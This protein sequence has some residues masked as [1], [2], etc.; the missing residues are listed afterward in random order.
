MTRGRRATG[1]SGGARPVF[2]DVDGEAQRALI[3]SEHKYRDL[4]EH[5]PD[6]YLTAD[7]ATERIID[8]NQTLCDRLGYTKAELVGQLSTIVYPAPPSPNEAAAIR[9]RF[10]DTGAL[11]N[12]ERMLRCKDGSTIPVS[13][14]VR[15]IRDAANRI[16]AIRAVWRDI[17][18]QKQAERDLR[19]M[20]RLGEILRSS[21]DEADVLYAVCGEVARHL[22]VPRCSFAE[23]DEPAGR[24]VI[25]R[26]VH[27]DYPSVAG[28]VSLAAFAAPQADEARG[29]ATAVVN[30]TRTDPRTA[31]RYAAAYDPISIRSWMATPLRRDGA[32]VASLVVADAVPRRWEDREIHLLG[33]IAERVWV[34]VEHMRMLAEHR[35]RSIREAVERSEAR[36]RQLVEA[37]HDYAVFMLDADGVITSWNAGAQRIKG[38]T[39]EEIIGRPLDVFYTEEDIERGHPRRVLERAHADGRYEE[40]GW[41]VRKD[42]SWFWASIALTTMRDAEGRIE[43]FAKVTRDITDRR[44][45]SE[46]LHARQRLLAQHVKERDVLLQEIHHRVKNNL[47]MISSLIHMQM[48]QLAPGP[49]KEVLE[50]CQNRVMAIALIHEKLYESNDYSEIQF[51]DY[52]RSLAANVFHTLHITRRDIA[53]D[54]AIDPI[55]LSIKRAIPCGLI[56]NELITNAL[57]YAF[58]EP[59]G[60]T[61]RVALSRADGQLQLEVRDDGVGFPDG[62]DLHGSASLGLRLVAMLTRQIGGSLAVDGRSGAR[63]R[64]AFPEG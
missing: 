58:P 61:L 28:E 53:L 14:N 30:D 56:I 18:T 4:F 32:W 29:G 16:V 2:R 64:I 17:T 42:G 10:A 22:G 5:S 7:M 26:D 27:G 8:C 19:L 1:S 6:M 9:A 57:K 34:W 46:E 43:G 35:D 11:D 39:A 36:F 21:P 60:G 37:I 54:L 15:A 41:R 13:L 49:S 12:I 62:W 31:Q 38:Y 47:Q 59:R 51:A 3:A 45:Q 20:I 52:A 24:A 40:E 25:R 44:R 23:V 63:F 33:V 55:P 48:R 50:E